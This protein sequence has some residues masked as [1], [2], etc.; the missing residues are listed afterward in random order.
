MGLTSQSTG[1][2]TLKEMFEIKIESYDDIVVALAGN[3]NTGKSTVFNSLTGLN[4]HTGN[5]PGKTVTN[6]QG[7]YK[8]KDKQYTLVDLPGT[9]SLLANS[10]EEQIARD[11]ICFGN[12]HVTVVVTDATSLERNLNLVLQIMEITNRVVVCVNLLDEANRKN[13]RVDLNKLERILGVPVVGT[14]A[15]SGKGLEELKNAIEKV[16]KDEIKINPKK[17]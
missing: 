10:I 2:A 11:F 7:R 16:A 3:P 9:Y 13:I 12:P 17:N 15:R 4:Q 6:A 5:W 14:I 8:Y 1:I